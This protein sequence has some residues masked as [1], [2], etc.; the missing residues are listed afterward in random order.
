MI[1]Q[2]NWN[3]DCNAHAV[4]AI[5]R[6]NNEA[7][8]KIGNYWEGYDRSVRSK[9]ATPSTLIG[10]AR[11]AQTLHQ[12]DGNLHQAIPK[13]RDVVIRLAKEME[14]EPDDGAT[15]TWNRLC[16][17][18][19]DKRDSLKQLN[20]WIYALVACSDWNDQSAWEAQVEKLKT[21]LSSVGGDASKANDFCAWNDAPTSTTST[22]GPTKINVFEHNGIEI[23]VG[24]IHSV[25]G[26][27]HDATLVLET[28]WQR[29]TD[30]KNALDWLIGREHDAPQP[31][32]RPNSNATHRFERFKRLHVAMTRP[33]HLLCLAI[34]SAH[35][36]DE[37][38]TS[39]EGIGWQ[40]TDLRQSEKS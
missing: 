10:F 33:R 30:I 5:A 40:I 39:L 27:T 32:G 22:S 35:I 16:D 23:K 37:Q 24:T 13:L 12:T 38:K 21:Y 28:K 19:Q 2:H 36:N 14:I 29:D 11:L 1:S 3:G 17:L 18:Y 7:N 20:E 9:S 25:K 31:D 34:N 6:P 8:L 26:E 15:L 4:G